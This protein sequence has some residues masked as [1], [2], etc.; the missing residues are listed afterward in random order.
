MENESK[1]II[2]GED[3]S[4]FDGGYFAYIG[5]NI[6]VGFLTAVTF[7]MA[8]PWL[9]CWYQKWLASHTVINGKRMSFDG[10]GGEF[11]AKYIIWLVLTW[12][13]CGIYGL[14]MAVEVKKWVT[15]HSHFEGEIDDNSFFDGK[16]GDFL[17]TSIL[18]VLACLLPFVGVAW[19]KI[20]ITRWFVDHT[21]IDS[22]RLVF[23][24]T[25]GDLFFK[26]LLWGILTSLTCGIFGLFVPVNYIKWETEHTITNEHTPEA[27]NLKANYKTQIHTEAVMLQNGESDQIEKIKA[28]MLTE[29]REALLQ[30]NV[31][32][33][34]GVIRLADILKEC[35]QEINGEDAALIEECIIMAR[36]LKSARP[37]NKKSKLWVIIVAAIVAFLMFIGTVVGGFFLVAW[38]I[39]RQAAMGPAVSNAAIENS[40]ITCE[41]FYTN[42]QTIAAKD[43]CT[44]KEVASGVNERSYAISD[45]IPNSYVEI[46]VED[47]G[48]N[49]TKLI[50]KGERQR[51]ELNNEYIVS[52]A[53]KYVYYSLNL[54][55]KEDITFNLDIN[56]SYTHGMW[57]FEFVPDEE[58]VTVTINKQ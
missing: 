28:Q 53:V 37:I 57:L 4:Y 45:S 49:L 21:I 11:F 51:G 25:T 14:W 31:A 29:A 46:W 39:E 32:K 48:T 33:L 44:I 12:F 26:Y 35:G 17:V 58:S 10:N 24:G 19:S 23:R 52:N 18:S 43:N 2:V 16:V 47:D 15:E 13:T 5:Y 34:D 7:G 22:Y 55:E 27:L 41:E 20:I 40:K 54:G 38:L 1:K 36:G 6:A 8:F 30:Y 50:I 42:M 9:K 3:G 56:A